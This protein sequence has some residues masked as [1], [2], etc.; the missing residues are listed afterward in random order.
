[1]ANRAFG[2]LLLA[3][4]L[5]CLRAI[6]EE[7]VLEMRREAAVRAR[8]GARRRG[9]RGDESSSSKTGSEQ[10][11]RDWPK[12]RRRSKCVSALCRPWQLTVAETQRI[13]NGDAKKTRREREACAHR[14]GIPGVRLP[15]VGASR[16]MEGVMPTSA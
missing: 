8:A 11:P 13:R 4:W 2:H 9:P 5:D 3:E 15:G 7:T 16:E 10:Q 14:A 6:P 12:R 1:M